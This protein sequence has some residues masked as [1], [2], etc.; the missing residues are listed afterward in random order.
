VEDLDRLNQELRALDQMKTEFV[1]LVSHELRAPLTNIRA[2]VE[3][4]LPEEAGVPEPARTSLRLIQEETARLGTFVEAILDLSALDAR[5]FPL[6]VAPLDFA[7]EAL[8]AVDRFASVPGHERIRMQLARG[9]PSVLADERALASVLYHLLDNGLK[10][11]PQ[12]AI[13]LGAEAEP[14]R[15]VAWVRDRGPGIPEADREKV[16]DMFHRLDSSD[17]REVYGHGL[18]LH[19]V[20]RLLEAMD[21]G[22]RCETASGGGARLFFWLPRSEVVAEGALGPHGSQAP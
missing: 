9:L 6:R 17:S 20:R 8:T 1:T 14:D 7:A 11:A 22:I 2:G 5:R 16:F 21:G 10:Y 12:G 3:L 4:L 15:L 19:L 18:G 13:D